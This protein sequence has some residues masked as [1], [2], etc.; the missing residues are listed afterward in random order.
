[1]SASPRYAVYWAPDADHPLWKA[2]C[3]WLGRDAA[4]GWSAAHPRE[5]AGEPRRYGFHATLKA[6]MRLREGVSVQDFF[7]AV[8]R[9]ASSN[10]S[11]AMPQLE[12]TTLRSFVALRPAAPI[13]AAHPLRQLAD[14]CVRELDALRRP[15]TDEERAQRLQSMAFDAV[16]RANIEDFGYAFAFDRWQFHMTLSD[17]FADADG[18]WR[19]RLMTEARQH[20]AHALAA[21]LRCTGLSVFVEPS[22]CSP[23]Q[24]VRRLPLGE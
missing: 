7:G 12:V 24:L 2:G 9:L 10:A 6:P 14:A 11:F 17:S 3:E 20:F 13:D 5:H 22:P 16:E 1:M 21:P 18:T 19:D 15:P 23:F 4:S 8:S